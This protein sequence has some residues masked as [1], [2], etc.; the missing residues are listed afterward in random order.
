MDAFACGQTAMLQME[1]VLG[2]HGSADVSESRSLFTCFFQ[3]IVFAVH[4]VLWRRRQ[5]K[6]FHLNEQE[7]LL[8]FVNESK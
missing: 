4:A 1:Q 2:Q 7:I 3:Q 5:A 8:R 6:L